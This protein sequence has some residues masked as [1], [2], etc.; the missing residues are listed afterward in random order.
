MRVLERSL[1]V[2]GRLPTV[3]AVVVGAGSWLAACGADKNHAERDR[4]AA[5][6]YP[7]AG[8]QGP[9]EELDLYGAADGCAPPP[10]CIDTCAPDPGSRPGV[11]EDVQSADCLQEEADLEFMPLKIWDFDGDLARQPVN[12]SVPCIP[13]NVPNDPL[14]LYAGDTYRYDDGSTNRQWPVARVGLLTTP[15]GFNPRTSLTRVCGQPHRAL[16]ISGGPYTNWGGGIGRALKCLN[17]GGV[18]TSLAGDGKAKAYERFSGVAAVAGKEKSL[19]VYCADPPPL[20]ACQ[21]KDD[22]AL[23]S[24]CPMRDRQ[25]ADNV[26]ARLPDAAQGIPDAFLLGQTLD[27]SQWDGLA[28][29]ARRGPDSQAGIR[30]L[31]GDKYV[32][33]EM[34]FLQYLVDPAAPRY[35]ECVKECDCRG[36]YQDCTPTTA[37]ITNGSTGNSEPPD[38]TYCFNPARGDPHP[39]STSD[40]DNCGQTACTSAEPAYQ[41]LDARF[42]DRPCSRWVSYTGRSQYLCYDPATDPR[43]AEGYERCGD[44][45]M[46]GIRLTTDWRL[47]LVPFTDLHQQ[48]WAKASDRMDLTSASVVRLTWDRGWI[49]YWIADVRLYR[50][51]R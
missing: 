24:L 28:I 23:S 7:D 1:L 31:V 48:G 18:E 40:Y 46:A 22:P 21:A 41:M 29:R 12:D 8:Y 14:D 27:L 17:R 5:Q 32:D 15:A 33:E 44:Y 11:P 39:L 43:P 42:E 10:P 45:W 51:K 26:L 34:S 38:Q 49:D 3:L 20:G 35:C 2:G 30:V 4:V 19:S 6:T 36:A 25:Y 47:H 16:H 37:P 13:R 50:W 9:D